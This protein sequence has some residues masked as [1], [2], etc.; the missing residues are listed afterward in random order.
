MTKTRKTADSKTTNDDF[1][2]TGSENISQDVNTDEAL[3][4]SNATMNSMAQMNMK[5]TYDLHQ[6]LDSEAI[7]N[8]RR[9]QNSEAEQR[10]RHA[11]EEHK[12]RLRHA[13]TEH[14]IKSMH[15]S[16]A[17]VGTSRIIEQIANDT[18]DAVIAAVK[19]RAS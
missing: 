1:L 14:T 2:M 7:I 13:D 18:V 10:M 16:G 5:R 12:M 4:V 17:S 19:A 8:A 15:L 3:S 9:L 11:E 6:T